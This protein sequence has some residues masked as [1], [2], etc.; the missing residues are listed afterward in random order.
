MPKFDADT[1]A[2]KRDRAAR[3]GELREHPSWAELRAVLEE[4]KA[5]YFRSLQRQLVSGSAVDQRY[6]DRVAGFFKGAEWILDN[7]D[8]AEK[9]LQNAIKRATRMGLLEGDEAV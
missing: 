4:R 3:L 1:V 8:L 5:V 6:I 2:K 7:P 9:S